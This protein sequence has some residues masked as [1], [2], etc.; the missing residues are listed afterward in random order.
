MIVVMCVHRLGQEYV[1]CVGVGVQGG[2]VEGYV[3]C[4]DDLYY[5]FSF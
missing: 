4:C 3:F 2:E 5:G 1:Y